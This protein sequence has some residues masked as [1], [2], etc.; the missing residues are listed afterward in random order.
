MKKYEGITLIALVV[1]IIVLLILAG[2]SLNLIS[3]SD[4]ILGRATSSENTYN[5]A[6]AKEQAELFIADTLTAYYEEVYVNKT[7][8]DSKLDYINNQ[9]GSGTVIG[10]YFL[11][12]ATSGTAKVEKIQ[13]VASLEKAYATAETLTELNIEVYRGNS[14]SGTK[15]LEGTIDI[16][17][18]ISWS[19]EVSQNTNAGGNDAPTD[20]DDNTEPPVTTEEYTWEKWSAK[21]VVTSYTYTTTPNYTFNLNYYNKATGEDL[22]YHYCVAGTDVSSMFNTTTGQFTTSNYVSFPWDGWANTIGSSNPDNRGVVY[23]CEEYVGAGENTF[24]SYYTMKGTKYEATPATREYQKDEYIE[25]I[26]DSS[27]NAYPDNGYKDGF[28]YIKK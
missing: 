15:I 10:D 2:V 11:K 9:I 16:N 6:S 20:E 19:N 8:S 14:T 24:A 27:S 26:T 21:T 13:A 25:D 3:G 7:F 22:Y 4:G 17:G 5:T 18:N 23:K 28:Y 1:T 12:V